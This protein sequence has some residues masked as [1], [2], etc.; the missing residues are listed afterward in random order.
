MS[1]FLLKKKNI[2]I[3]DFGACVT[4]EITL[5]ETVEIFRVRNFSVLF[6]NGLAISLDYCSLSFF[7]FL[8]NKSLL[9]DTKSI[10]NDAHESLSVIVYT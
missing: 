5:I 1:K 4:T 6:H 10:N 2:R 7:F 9:A 3:N 8:M